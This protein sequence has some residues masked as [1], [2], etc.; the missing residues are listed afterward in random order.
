MKNRID[1]LFEQKPGGVLSVYFT[2]GY[3]QLEDTMPI[4]QSLTNNGVDMIEIGMPFSDPL[5]DGPVIQESSQKALRNGMSI[6]KLFDQIGAVREKVNIPLI[7]MGYLNPV[8]HYGLEKFCRKAA[9]IGIDGLILPDLPVEEYIESYQ[10]IFEQHHLHNIMLITPQ[11]K[12]ERLK[13]I[14]DNTGG[15]LYMVSAASTTG[16]KKGF[17]LEQL[18]YFE[19]IQKMNLSVP[20]LIGFGISSH[21]TYQKACEYANGVIIGSAFIRA[22]DEEGDTEEKVKRFVEGINK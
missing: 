12:P 21:E 15:F 4:I 22:L 19:R 2:A 18:D 17:A 6:S 1:S 5:A 20:R 8:L 14:A 3:P 9:E 10:E 7:L 11:T 13:L 16:A